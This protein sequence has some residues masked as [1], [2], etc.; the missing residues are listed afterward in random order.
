MEFAVN[1]SSAAAEL[2]ARG[3]I[4]TDRFKCP[5]W[6]DLIDRLTSAMP[7]IPIHVHFPLLVGTGLGHPIDT[8]TGSVP[9]WARIED[10]MARTG[11]RWV[12][13]HLGPRPEDHPGLAERP[14]KDQ[15]RTVTDALIHDLEPLVARFGAERVVGENIFEF[16]GMHL[17]AAV[18]PEVLTTVIET[19]GCGLLLDLSHA[20]LAAR[21]LGVDAREYIDALPVNYLRELHVTGIQRFDATWVERMKATGVGATKIARLAG[22]WID[23]LPMT[24]EDWSFF[25][26]AIERIREGAWRTPDI[27]AFEYGGIGPEFEALTLPKEL[28]TQVPRLYAM[29]HNREA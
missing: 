23:H 20:R 1:Y 11:T 10:L 9:D 28:A 18:M 22:Q 14:W 2:M 5:A 3:A 24:E 17:R 21:D 29:V 26:W 16:F 27:V 25:A 15:V 6:P 7:Q 19:V 4:T 8:E 13:A 12:S